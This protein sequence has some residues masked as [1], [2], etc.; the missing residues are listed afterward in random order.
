MRRLRD[1]LRTL[2]AEI[3][4]SAAVIVGWTLLT[5]GVAR[6]TGPNAWIVSGGLFL[7]SLAGWRWLFELF[8]KGLYVMS[9]EADE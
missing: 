9:L 7:L 3:A 5:W 6:L 4:V 2:V 8:W 1:A